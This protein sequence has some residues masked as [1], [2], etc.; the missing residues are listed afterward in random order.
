MKNRPNGL[1]PGTRIGPIPSIEYFP[2][3]PSV[4][5]LFNS[6]LKKESP[7]CMR[8][9]FKSSPLPLQVQ[10]IGTVPSGATQILLNAVMEE[11]TPLTI[12]V[13]NCFEML[14]RINKRGLIG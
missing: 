8:W 3:L 2:G 4:G 13:G 7:K 11:A 14:E 6:N 10:S 5:S 1:T 9:T 12:F